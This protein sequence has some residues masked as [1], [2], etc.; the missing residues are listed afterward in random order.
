MEPS[1]EDAFQG[2]QNLSLDVRQYFKYYGEDEEWNEALTFCVTTED[3]E[4]D[5]LIINFYKESA[6]ATHFK[7]QFGYERNG[8]WEF[9]QREG[10]K[11]HKESYDSIAFPIFIST[12]C[13]QLG[14]QIARDDQQSLSEP[15]FLAIATAMSDL[16]FF[17]E[18]VMMAKGMFP[19]LDGSNVYDMIEAV[20]ERMKIEKNMDW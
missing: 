2:M 15:H 12:F 14:W 3:P 17:L 13:L 6:D 4:D 19:S 7:L 16:V 9:W 10:F 5:A 1:L 20:F 11:E 18:S 8:E